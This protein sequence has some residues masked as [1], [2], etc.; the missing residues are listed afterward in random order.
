VRQ[1]STIASLAVVLLAACAQADPTGDA[2][3]PGKEAR[4][5]ASVASESLI[6]N[7]AFEG[8]LAPWSTGGAKLPILSSAQE[9]GGTTSLRC[10]ATSAPGQPEPNGDSYAYQTVSIPADATQATLSF[11]YYAKTDD[12]IAYD[13]QDAQVLDEDYNLLVN[14]FHM[15][16]DSQAWKQKTVDLSAYR[17]RTLTI[18]FNAHGDGYTDPTTLWID[19]VALEV[20]T[21]GGGGGDEALQNGVPVSAMSGALGSSRYFQLA[22]PAG[23]SNLVFRLGTG[24]SAAND[25][26][27]YVRLGGRPTLA[28]HDCQS[29]ASG[30]TETCSLPAQAGS[31]G[32]LVYGYTAYSGAS[33]VATYTS[34]NG[35]S[36]S[37]HTTLG[38]PDG[39]T[40]DVAN[41]QH[42]L[43]VKPQYVLSYN[44]ARKTPNWVSWEL[45][46]SYLGST[47]RQDTFR[48]D[49]TL[50]AGLP[51]ATLADYAGSGYTRGHM[52]PSADR[53]LT[54]T[55]NSA[56]FYLT[57]MVPQAAENNS[58]AWEKLETY[59]RDLARAGKEL[60]IIS[61]GVYDA[62][63]PPKTI[64]PGAVQ[65]P[66][67]TYKVVVVLDRVGAG[68][69][70]VT[71]ATRVIA[72]LMP[73]DDAVVDRTD[74]WQR[75]RVTVDQIESETQLDFLSEVPAAVQ[76]VIEAHV[77]AQ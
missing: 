60:F 5:A 41:A 65:V 14:V 16:D 63:A 48:T 19:D 50:P 54:I 76:A 40:A 46:A 66:I 18:L 15:A 38:L 69:A 64:G 68:A 22:V 56:T 21:G 47:A 27:L 71:A 13:W 74:D 36:I 33:L 32:V 53:T 72:V 44:S 45:N 75:Y 37:V 73:N 62:G 2:A 58:G 8:S 57:N 23:A 6:A 67:S 39:A 20:A 11:W 52:C 28:A 30:L 26:D 77:D 49:S 35:A 24:T 51:Q 43:S 12:T 4:L 70:D 42:Y 34:Q 1:K 10:G 3:E 17:G 7:G 59:E 9:H 31:Y 55:D 61:G 29:I 25:A